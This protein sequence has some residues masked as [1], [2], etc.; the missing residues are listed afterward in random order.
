MQR[1]LL[2]GRL[3]REHKAR[4]CDEIAVVLGLCLSS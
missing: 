2:P 4:K 1:G 3:A